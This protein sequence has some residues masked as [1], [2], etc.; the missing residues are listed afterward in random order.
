MGMSCEAATKIITELYSAPEI[1]D[2]IS[3][4][5]KKELGPDFKQELFLILLSVP[6]EKVEQMNGTFKYFVVRIILNLVRQEKNIFHKTYLDKTIEYDTDKLNYQTISPADIDT[7]SERQQRENE[8]E[9]IIRRF[10]II[11]REL[12]N[13][14]Y[15][16]H[17]EMIKLLVECGSNRE[18]SRRTGIPHTTVDRTINH[19][20][21]Y[22]NK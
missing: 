10:E 6:C 7:I 5:V 1:D 21:K 9:R 3:K 11:D 12:G 14:S 13:N 22:F 2:C 8:E 17:K 16:Y 19:V 15:P 20:R 18:V 4:L